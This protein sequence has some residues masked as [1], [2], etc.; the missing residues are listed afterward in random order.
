MSLNECTVEDAA[1]AWFEDL[2]YAIKHG[3]HLAPGEQAAERNR[4]TAEMDEVNSF[5]DMVLVTRLREAIRRLNP[6]IPEGARE[7]ALRKLLRVETP[8]LT[9]TNR[10]FHRMLRDRIAEHDVFR[11]QGRCDE[12]S[13]S[14]PNGAPCESPGQR[15][16]NEPSIIPKP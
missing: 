15:P 10:V 14:S 5:G 8:S 2:G 4:S 6:V 7:E 9:Q 16:G 12:T 3:P 13:L 1:L 11:I